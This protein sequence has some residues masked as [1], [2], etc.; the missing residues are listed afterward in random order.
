M[1]RGNRPPEDMQPLA[2]PV[3]VGQAHTPEDARPL[4]QPV[5]AQQAQRMH[6]F[7]GRRQQAARE[8]GHDRTWVYRNEIVAE[9]EAMGLNEAQS[10]AM[11]R[12]ELER[13]WVVLSRWR[14]ERRFIGVVF[15]DYYGLRRL[16]SR[17]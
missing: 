6:E 11:A 2:R 9:G 8:A 16:Y 5:A 13:T 7:F 4:A 14:E 10:L 3:G 17:S 12:D 1:S 15:T